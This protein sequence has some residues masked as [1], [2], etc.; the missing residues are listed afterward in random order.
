MEGVIEIHDEEGAAD[1]IRSQGLAKRV[2]S[3]VHRK[4]PG[5]SWL[6]DVNIQGGVVTLRCPKISM[7]MAFYIYLHRTDTVIEKMAVE[8]AGNILEAYNVARKKEKESDLSHIEKTL[9]GNARHRHQG[10]L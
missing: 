1:I 6:V 10:G 2:G 3:A 9:K 8:A 5:V 4:Y 7:E